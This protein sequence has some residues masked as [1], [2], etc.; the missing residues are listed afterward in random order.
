MIQV[1][2]KLKNID[3]SGAKTVTCIG[4]LSGYKQRYAS[5]G[6]I[7]TVSVQ[8]LRKRRRALAK[9]KKGQVLQA[10]IVRTKKVLVKS[11][12]LFFFENS[13]ILLNKQKKLVGTR[14]FGSLPKIL[15]F[16]KYLRIAFLARGLII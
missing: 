9:V 7:I 8:K 6:E 12:N 16:N 1:G 3:N 15:R 10:L 5:F 14:V 11:S 2:T 13:V 4:C